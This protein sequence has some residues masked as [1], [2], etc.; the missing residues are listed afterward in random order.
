[1][2]IT[3]PS[4]LYTFATFPPLPTRPGPISA[5]RVGTKIQL[6]WNGGGVLVTRPCLT[7]GTWTPVPD[8][9][10]GIQIDTP[11]TPAGYYQLRQ[12]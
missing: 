10:S 1:M 11:T 4:V 3:A 12:Q 5:Q 2:D 9:V 8:A 6:N 7:T